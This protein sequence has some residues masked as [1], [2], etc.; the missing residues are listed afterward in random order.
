MEPS[1]ATKSSVFFDDFFSAKHQ[2][3]MMWK[4]ATCL[5]EIHAKEVATF[6]KRFI[7]TPPRKRRW[8]PQEMEVWFR[9]LY[10][11]GATR[12]WVNRTAT[13]VSEKVAMEGSWK[14][15]G[16]WNMSRFE[17]LITF[18]VFCF[19]KILEWYYYLIIVVNLRC[20]N[21]ISYDIF[22]LEVV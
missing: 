3:A 6:L 20:W 17:L 13:E 14:G 10:F 18:F 2:T 7:Y 16:F 11:P 5:P 19:G 22:L 1:V 9:W 8:N 15:W 4:D 21:D 12:S